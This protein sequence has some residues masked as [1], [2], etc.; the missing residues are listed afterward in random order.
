MNL[1]SVVCAMMRLRLETGSVRV[2]ISI[3]VE[4]PFSSEG[5]LETRFFRI[6]SMLH[7]GR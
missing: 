2:W 3:G 4:L 1:T 7:D 6:W 5:K